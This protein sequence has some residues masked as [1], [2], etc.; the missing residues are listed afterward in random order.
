M[1]PLDA[2]CAKD[3]QNFN[4]AEGMDCQKNKQPFI[5]LSCDN[6]MKWI[7]PSHYLDWSVWMEILLWK[8][9]LL[10]MQVFLWSP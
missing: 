10:K 5:H 4:F 1:V 8:N 2:A 7:N 9:V 3:L 6:F